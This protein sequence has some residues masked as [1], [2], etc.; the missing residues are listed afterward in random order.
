MPSLITRTTNDITQLQMIVA[1]GLQMMIKSPVMAVWAVIKILG[2]SWE[3]SAVTAGFVVAIVA[4]ILVVMTSVLPR[5]R[6]VQ[7]LT[8]KINRV[9][10]ET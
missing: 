2:K 6:L 4:L 3:L 1:M 7:K 10:R 5:F 9:A 8:D